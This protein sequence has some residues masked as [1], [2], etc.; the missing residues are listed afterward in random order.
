MP[1][2]QSDLAQKKETPLR[3]VFCCQ[4]FIDK[5]PNKKLATR[6]AF[7]YYYFGDAG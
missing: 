7:W 3:R 5:I 1:E 6:T 2:W 4:N